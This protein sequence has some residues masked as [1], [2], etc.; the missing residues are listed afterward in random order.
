MKCS[1][2]AALRPLKEARFF[3]GVLSGQGQ[4]IAQENV[5]HAANRTRCRRQCIMD[6]TAANIRAYQ[7]GTPQNVVNK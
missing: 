5:K 3:G 2:L 1:K 4:E 6:I 7:D